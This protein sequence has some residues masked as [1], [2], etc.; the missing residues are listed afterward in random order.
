MPHGDF[1]QLCSRLFSPI[2]AGVLGLPNPLLF[3]VI[4]G[5]G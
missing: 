1:F 3:G 4:A 5:I 2:S